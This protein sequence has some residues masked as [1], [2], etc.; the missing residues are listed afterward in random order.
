MVPTRTESLSAL[1]EQDETAWLEAMADLIAQHRFDECDLE[2]LAEYL[3]DM[4]R[5]DRREVESRL[6]VLMRHLLKWDKQPEKR[7][8]SWK[9][10][11]IHQRDELRN[12]LESG[13]LRNHA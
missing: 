5:R 13:T 6:T 10:T 7:S 2:H 4:A 8:G 11:I 1:Y 3:H 12:L 9:R